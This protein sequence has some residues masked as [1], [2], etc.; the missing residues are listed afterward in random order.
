[1]LEIFQRNLQILPLDDEILYPM[2][3]FHWH[4]SFYRSIILGVCAWH[5]FK[6]ILY[7]FFG[8]LK[9]PFKKLADW[10]K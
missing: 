9:E 5:R 8:W 2:L 6:D 10:L 3:C 1:M 4:A 7:E